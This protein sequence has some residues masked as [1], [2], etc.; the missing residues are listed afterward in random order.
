MSYGDQIPVKCTHKLMP[1]VVAEQK[2][3]TDTIDQNVSFTINVLKQT[4]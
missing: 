4:N 1:H 3:N 2:P